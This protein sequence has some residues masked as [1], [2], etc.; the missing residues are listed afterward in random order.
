MGDFGKGGLDDLSYTPVRCCIPCIASVVVEPT[1]ERI[2]PDDPVIA[3]G[4][5]KHRDRFETSRCNTP[6]DILVDLG[7]VRSF[8]TPPISDKTPSDAWASNGHSFRQSLAEMG[9]KPL[10][11]IK[12]WVP[13]YRLLGEQQS[14]WWGLGEGCKPSAKP[15]EGHGYREA[16][17]MTDVQLGRNPLIP[18]DFLNLENPSESP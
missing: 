15:L 17:Q 12:S 6:N 16:I 10:L 14:L 8:V 11:S 1:P 13:T 5:R 2:P 18:D 3:Q 9:Q 4:P 7:A